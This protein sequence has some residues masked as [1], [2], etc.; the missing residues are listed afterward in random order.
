MAAIYYVSPSG[1]D[2]ND[3][4]SWG[5]AKKNIQTAINF[6]VNNYPSEVWIAAGSYNLSE[7]IVMAEGI[8]VYGGFL[9]TEQSLAERPR[10]V[11]GDTTRAN[12]TKISGLRATSLLMQLEAFSVATI[13]N[14]ISFIR[15]KSF[16]HG[17][18]VSIQNG[19][20]LQY[21]NVMYNEAQGMGGGI[22]AING[23]KVSNCYIAHNKSI[24]GGGG[25]YLIS[26]DV[27]NTN[28]FKNQATRHGGGVY[29]PYKGV[30]QRC[31]FF[32]NSTN[33][34]GGGIYATNNSRVAR[35]M[36]SNNFAAQGYGGGMFGEGVVSF[37]QDTITANI[38]RYGAGIYLAEGVVID[39]C[40]ITKNNA[41]ADAGGAFADNGGV[42]RNSFIEDNSSKGRGAGV[43]AQRGNFDLVNTTVSGNLAQ[44]DGGGIYSQ[45]K[46]YIVK[47]T[48]S[49]NRSA[50]NGGGAFLYQGALCDSSVFSGNFGAFGG[51]LY[52]ASSILTNCDIFDNSATLTGGA[53]YVL[54]LS[55]VRQCTLRS[56]T[57]QQEGGAIYA[58]NNN[59][60]DRLYVTNN[61]SQGN[62]GGLFLRQDNTATNLVVANNQA[63]N[64]GGVYV[65]FENV[66]V[67]ATIVRNSA[68]SGGGITLLSDGQLTNSII[69]GNSG[70]QVQKMG[71]VTETYCAIENLT[72]VAYN[73]VQ[74]SQL[75]EN[76]FDTL[77]NAPYFVKP[78][79]LSGTPADGLAA[80]WRLQQ[81][82]TCIDK[83]NN[84]AIVVTA[85]RDLVG[86]PRVFNYGIVDI[87]AYEWVT[88]GYTGITSLKQKEEIRVYP[89]PA[90]DIITINASFDV[91]RVLAYSV[92]GVLLYEFNTVNN[93]MIDVG[94]LPKGII[95]LR[96]DGQRKTAVARLIKQ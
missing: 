62:G 53:V 51:G 17:G 39:S 37:L 61:S 91:Q 80:D 22:A 19:G 14:G 21:C 9:G 16:T 55:T 70:G 69:W 85:R 45:N 23:A 84:G 4:L 65:Q 83:G 64:G 68:G 13:W 40:I 1:S 52:C 48:I 34:N 36:F 96:I 90:K 32:E 88:D 33:A 30:I 42:I 74:L 46:G 8:N 66:I 59:L 20:E 92:V 49:K 12:L 75:N 11:L 10:I 72:V 25:L 63:L 94:R 89:N 54:D 29:S 67:G 57:A 24:E 77:L 35:S 71:N 56:N 7:P 38:A 82:S 79:T 41:A 2:V 43:F 31:S 27:S 76:T 73:N 26:A 81:R 93:N 86:N 3:G 87:G 50:A 58:G 44:G 5:R 28:F 95:L 60:L 47:S 6:A 18:A 15:G 78:T